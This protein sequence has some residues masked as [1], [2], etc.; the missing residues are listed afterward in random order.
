M[1]YLARPPDFQNH[2]AY[3]RPAGAVNTRHGFENRARPGLLR[4]IFDAFIDGRQR[5]M[6]REID[7]YVAWHS[8][9][10]TDSFERELGARMTSGDWNLRR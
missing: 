2:V 10:F 6:Q 5:R 1:A 7:R 3:Y 9:S 8:R 4:R